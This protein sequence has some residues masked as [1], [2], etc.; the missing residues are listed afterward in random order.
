MVSFGIDGSFTH[1]LHFQ[2]LKFPRKVLKAPELSI[3]G[4]MNSINILGFLVDDS[5]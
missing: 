2:S 3:T 1:E 4:A 5:L